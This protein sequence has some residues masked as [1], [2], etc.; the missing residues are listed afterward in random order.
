MT[1]SLVE[2][3]KVKP[4]HNLTRTQC[5]KLQLT[6]P[7]MTAFLNRSYYYRP[8]TGSDVSLIE[9]CHFRVYVT[10]CDL[11]KF[12]SADTT[13]DIWRHK[14]RLPQLSCSVAAWW[15]V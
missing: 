12:F 3:I 9:S 15:H 4:L 14:T 2:L 6:L 8:L 1:Y 5:H 13:T 11:E 10:A 7:Q